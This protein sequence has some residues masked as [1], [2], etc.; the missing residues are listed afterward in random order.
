MP[1]AMA[2]PRYSPRALTTSKVV[3]VPKSTT[4]APS[5]Q[6]SCAATALTIRSAPTSRGFS[7]RTGTP[8]FVPGP[9]TSGVRF[10]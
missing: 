7:V 10:R 8:V 9:T 5:G 6:R 3:A 1:G 4:I 2:P